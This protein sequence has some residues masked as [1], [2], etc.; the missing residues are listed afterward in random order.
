MVYD[1]DI[2]DHSTC[3]KTL[4]CIDNRGET[5]SF[6]FRERT[7]QNDVNVFNAMTTYKLEDLI[8]LVGSNEC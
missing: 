3:F 8:H 6:G 2:S 7:E 4:N 1:S 5:M